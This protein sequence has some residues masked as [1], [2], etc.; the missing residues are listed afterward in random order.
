[1]VVTVDGE[2]D[3]LSL[4]CALAVVCSGSER[5]PHIFQCGCAARGS[6]ARVVS[7]VEQQL[8]RS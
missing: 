6:Q 3:E 8:P 1:M 5:P 4:K 2:A 7:A